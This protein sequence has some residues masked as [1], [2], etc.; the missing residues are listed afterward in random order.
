MDRQRE[1]GGGLGFDGW[2]GWGWWFGGR[3]LGGAWVVC[4]WCVVWGVGWL[5]GDGV[6]V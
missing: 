2:I 5:K 3:W 6:A 1:L 4:G